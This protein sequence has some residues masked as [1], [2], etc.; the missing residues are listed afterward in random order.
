MIC[1]KCG[2]MNPVNSTICYNCKNQI[3]QEQVK[4]TQQLKQPLNKNQKITIISLLSIIIILFTLILIL[5][6][7]KEGNSRT[8]M[9]YVAGSNLESDN[10]I[11]TADLDAIKPSNINLSKTNILLYTGGTKKWHNFV[12]N[13]DNGIY[14]LKSNGFEK[15]ESQQQYSLGAPETLTNFLKYAYTNYKTD[16]YDLILY[17]HGGAI[18]GAIY[19]DISDDNL[20]LEDMTAALKNSPFNEQNKLEAVIFRTCL[21]GTI[22]LANIYSSYAK[23]LIGSEEI[24]W[25]SNYTDVLSFLNKVTIDDNGYVFGEKFIESYENQ[26]SILNRN[27]TIK[28]TY[29]LIDLSKI[30]EV[31]KALDEYV[32]GI[33]LSKNY[34]ELVKIRTAAYQYGDTS[35]DY[36]MIDLYNFA[37]KTSN[38]S[39]KSNSRLLKAI[40]QAVVY[41]KTNEQESHGLSIYFPFNGRKAIKYKYLSVYENLNYSSEYK[42]LINNFNNMRNSG[43]SFS[44]SFNDSSIKTKTESNTTEIQLTKEQIEN[45]AFSTFTIFER[46][47]EHQNYYKPI[48]NSDNTTL[49][50]NG[51]LKINYTNSLTKI[52]DADSGDYHYILTYYRQKQDTKFTYGILYDD[53]AKF[54]DSN[55][56]ANATLYLTENKNGNLTLS[57]AKLNSKNE[58]I[59]GVLI[60][61]DDYEKY[62]I[63]TNS[64]RIIDSSGKVLDTSEWESAPIVTG[65]GGDLEDLEL[66]YSSLDKGD[67]YF[68]LFIISDINGNS[69]YSKLIKVGE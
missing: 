52:K 4:N 61:V 19:D 2:K 13:K 32:S 45:Y 30:N 65:F 69:S 43:K 10:A 15:L 16:K 67:N 49:D 6:N 47:Q 63:W 57:T 9:I 12:S 50:E 18:D 33:D 48:Y 11:V 28:H 58:R 14:I 40:E 42:K 27:N 17:N 64:Y 37:V 25:G 44:F 3:N 38:Y 46:D 29:S 1:N 62:E 23:Y 36:D 31:N 8:V 5:P 54:T 26:M 39:T 56:S 60:N 41:N 7:G 53:D 34:N 20:S 24:S 59:D 51:V 68:A 55:F 35:N 66:E 21:N 22:E